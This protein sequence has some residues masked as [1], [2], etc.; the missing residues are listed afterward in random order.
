MSA[1]VLPDL[2]YSSPDVF[3]RYKEIVIDGEL[4]DVGMASFAD[5]LKENDV[6]AI[7][8]YVLRQAHIAYAAEQAAKPAAP[9][10]PAPSNGGGN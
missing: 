3:A 2:R 9:A 4:K 7:Q 8:A 1:G 10:E 6:K 5:Y